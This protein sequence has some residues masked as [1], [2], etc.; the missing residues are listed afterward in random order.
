MQPGIDQRS[1]A[2]NENVLPIRIVVSGM[3]ALFREPVVVT[4]QG[5]RGGGAARVTDFGTEL[6]RRYRRSSATQRAVA[7]VSGRVDARPWVVRR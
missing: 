1:S 2:R 7:G 5:G 3:N 4:K 6:V